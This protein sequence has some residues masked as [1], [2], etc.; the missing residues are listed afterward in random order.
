[1]AAGAA[2]GAGC[3]AGGTDISGLG[4]AL[5]GKGVPAL[6][7][8]EFL[9]NMLRREKLIGAVWRGC[10]GNAKNPSDV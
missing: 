10:C 9:L 5:G 6:A 7:G 4:G 2:E 3:G 8:G 1:M